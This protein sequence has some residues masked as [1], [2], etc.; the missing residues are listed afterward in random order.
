[1]KRVRTQSWL[2]LASAVAIG[3]VLVWAGAPRPVP[4]GKDW[5]LVSTPTVGSRTNAG[6][7]TPA[8]TFR[9]SNVG[10]RRVDFL[11]WWFECRAKGARTLLATNQLA[12]VYIPLPPGKSTNLTMDVLLGAVPV[13]DCLCCYQVEWFESESPWRSGA[14]RL[15]RW[16]FDLF[17]VSWEPPWQPQHLTN[18]TTFAA[19]VE[20]ADYFRW[21]YGFTRT[22]WLEDLA[23]LQSA[24][25]QS[26][27]GVAWRLSRPPTADER[28]ESDARGAFV[29]FCQ[30][31]TNSTRDAEPTASPNAAPPHR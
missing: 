6:A 29:E 21:M 3:L 24:R 31:S 19:N 1:M 30:T 12:A 2:V 23:R 13:A 26:A 7:T 5:L 15:G 28:L 4:H 14:D 27:G 22:Q 17:E 9:V 10:P 18:G 25:T 11:V 8:V 16:W 20:V